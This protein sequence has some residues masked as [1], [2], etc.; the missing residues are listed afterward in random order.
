VGTGFMAVVLSLT[1]GRN[2]LD[3]SSADANYPPIRGGEPCFGGHVSLGKNPAEMIQRMKAQGFRCLQIHA[4]S[5]RTWRVPADCDDRFGA[6]RKA[7]RDADMALFLHAIYLINLASEDENIAEGSCRMLAWSM[8]AAADLGAQAVTFHVGSHL[9]RGFDAVRERVA[10]A[11]R[12]VLDNSPAGPLLLLEN[13]AGAGGCI[14][15]SLQELAAIYDDVGRPDNLGVCLDTA[16][17]FAA[18][19]DLRTPEGVAMVLEDIDRYLGLKALMAMHLNDSKT[20][21]HSGRDRHENIGA[22]FIGLSGFANLL[23]RSE[24]RSRPLILE[25]PNVERR[26]EELFTLSR[27]I[28][29]AH[30][31]LTTTGKVSG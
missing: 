19:Y 27:L 25:T 2:R 24:I 13:S 4:S 26:E 28:M 10:A 8:S 11:V 31:T 18:G 21:L 22:G 16:H 5:P 7:C 6:I 15:G 3:V 30:E 23:D 1:Q 17:A 12:M 20:D 14:G 9:G 29:N